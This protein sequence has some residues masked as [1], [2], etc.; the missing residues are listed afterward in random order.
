MLVRDVRGWR[1]LTMLLAILLISTVPQLNSLEDKWV[2][3]IETTTSIDDTQP[4]FEDQGS[5]NESSE[6]P[7]NDESESESESESG[8]ADSDDSEA[9]MA[10]FLDE[11]YEEENEITNEPI[12]E[13]QPEWILP[14]TQVIVMT[15]MAIICT[16]IFSNVVGAQSDSTSWRGSITKTVKYLVEMIRLLMKVKCSINWGTVKSKLFLNIWVMVCSTSLKL[17]D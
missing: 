12:I 14:A 8:E 3:S 13:Q 7:S 10:V 15:M 6:N 17:L 5:E 1:I 9:D 4:T 11:E 16:L 2:E